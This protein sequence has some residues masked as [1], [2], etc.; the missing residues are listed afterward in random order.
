MSNWNL[1]IF[2]FDRLQVA[3]TEP[4]RASYFYPLVKSKNHNNILS[5]GLINEKTSSFDP[6]IIELEKQQIHLKCKG[7]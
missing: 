2:H 4:L 3:T 5:K 7:K 6:I 1:S